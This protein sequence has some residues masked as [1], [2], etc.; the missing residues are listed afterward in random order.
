MEVLEVATAIRL[1]G[2][3]VLTNEPYADIGGVLYG[4][5]M[6]YSILTSIV[7]SQVCPDQAIPL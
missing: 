1:I 6:R 2:G 7:I 3:I 5:Y 4:P